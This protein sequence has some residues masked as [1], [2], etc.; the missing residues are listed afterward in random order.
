MQLTAVLLL[1]CCLQVAG[2]AVAQK[3]TLSENNASLKKVLNAI[4][5]QTGYAFF[6]NEQIVEKGQPVTIDVQNMPLEQVLNQCF[7]NQPLTYH[8]VNKTIVVSAKTERN[9][10]FLLQAATPPVVVSGKVTDGVNNA[11]VE[12]ATITVKG[13]KKRTVTNKEG[14]FTIDAEPGSILVISFVGFENREIAI[15]DARFLSIALTPK[16]KEAPL[17][18]VVITG[19]QRIRKES[20]TGTAISVSG[21]DLKKMNPQNILQSIQVFDPSFKIVQNNVL[22]SNPNRLPVINVRGNT[23]IPTGSNEVLS[24]SNLTGNTNLPTFILDGYEVSLEKVYDL[25][26]N[27][28]QSITL[29]K[30]AAATAIYG[31]RAANGVLVITTI[32]PQE[33]KLQLSYNYELNPTTPDL[34]DYHVLN[35][36]DKLEYERLAGLYD[37]NK[38]Q[39][40]T[41]SQLDR[42]YYSKKENVVGGVN[43]YWLSQPLQTG[44]GQKHSAYL[45]GGNKSIR[46]GLELRYHTM[47]GVMKGS[48]R[49]RYSA[50]MNLS[51]S[52][53]NRFIFKNTLTVTQVD[54]KESPYGNFA[55]YVKTNP[56]Y[57]KTDSVGNTVR[58]LETWQRRE[59]ANMAIE[60][61]TMLNPMY[62]ATLKSFIK[63]AYLELI[64]AF[65]AEWNINKSLR[66]R[67]QLSVN[68]TKYTADDFAS[69][70]ANE[71][72]YYSTN[73]YKLKGRYIYNTSDMTSVD[74]NLLVS[75]NKQAGNH[76]INFTAGSNFRTS[77]TD[78]K[79]FTAVGFTNDR[80]SN[81]GY[82]GSYPDGSTPQSSHPQTRLA[83]VLASV[84]Y[85]F[86]NKYLMDLSY[87]LDGSSTFGKDQRMAPFGSIGLG[88]NLH[89]EKFFHNTSVSQLKIRASTGI[90]GSVSFP[91]FMGITSYNYYTN[92][93]YATGIGASVSSLGND[94]LKWQKTT[95][96]DA[97]FDLGLFNDKIFISPRYYYKYTKGLLSNI[98]L[99]PSTGSTGKMANLGDMQNTGWEV[100]IKAT[101]FKNNKW[102]VG[103]FT[104]LTGNKNKIVKISNSLKKYNDKADAAQES[105]DYK[106]VPLL[107]YNEGQSTDAIYAVRSLGIDPENGKELFLKRNGQ[108][109]YEWD[110]KD[111]LP[112]ID[113]TPKAYGYFG[114]SAAYKN[115]LVTATFY[116]RFGGYDYNQTLVDRIENADPRYNVDQ[117]VF[118]EKWKKPGDHTFYKNISDL[119]Q[120]QTSSRFIQKDNVIELSSLYASYDFNKVVISRLGMKTLRLAV[121]M[122][123]IWRWGSVKLERGLEYPFA[124]NLTFSLQTRF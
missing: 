74:G 41:Q 103:I 90:T 23:A 108:T 104:N 42:L 72:Y 100:N 77:N 56:Y 31:S 52:P 33:G 35:A 94:E 13:T 106:G 83:S 107:R 84:N 21:E 92:Q 20:F 1:T 9:A 43:T 5:K 71:F 32:P 81:I 111:I 91:P 34:S 65:S 67:G 60:N 26:I 76:F 24:R 117:R 36:A 6:L 121:T 38:N 109:T 88:W 45:E 96:Y 87:R 22:G 16:A 28:V 105:D 19:F 82:A 15:T 57:A 118:D 63:S 4:K 123:D 48:E 116:T 46:Y 95:N 47:P 66:L 58:E 93:W 17:D 30:D 62:N 25:D 49:N 10:T 122:N 119:G 124:R 79:G 44:F 80:F 99:A 14:N 8:I 102:N 70:L 69:P 40:L 64:D 59:G 75:Y 54:T 12:S 53:D 29:L 85:T 73:D 115:F 61:F 39:A 11:P 27:R 3:V 101:V 18:D 120:T 98:I 7:Q 114:A 51:Y 110:V 50:G 113:A 89:K 86:A 68:K 37:A 78:N 112:I 2:A 55:D 97:G